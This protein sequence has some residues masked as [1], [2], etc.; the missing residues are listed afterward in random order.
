MRTHPISLITLLWVSRR[1]QGLRFWNSVE[2]ILVRVFQ[3]TFP[4]WSEEVPYRTEGAAHAVREKL[5][6]K[7]RDVK[8]D[9]LAYFDQ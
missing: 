6:P 4:Y 2:R 9:L 7:C 1:T 8:S 3:R 5:R